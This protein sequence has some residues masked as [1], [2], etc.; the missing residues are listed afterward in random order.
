MIKNFFVLVTSGHCGVAAYRA[1]VQHPDDGDGTA[2]Y[3]AFQAGADGLDL[4]QFWH[5]GTGYSESASLSSASPSAVIVRQAFS[6]AS[7]SAAFF[8]RPSPE[9]S[10]LLP[11]RTTARNSFW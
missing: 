1:R 11:T 8:E 4:G 2:D 9:P 5:G 3:V 6:A 7:C 10:S